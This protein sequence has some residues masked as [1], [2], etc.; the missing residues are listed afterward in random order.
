MQHGLAAAIRDTGR[1]QQES[2]RRVT[3]GIAGQADVMGKIQRD[4]NDIVHLQAVLHQNLSALASASNFEEA[5]HSLTAA[6]HML[7][8]R[9]SGTSSHVHQGK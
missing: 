4:A 7:T 1:D 8:A 5:V 2:L 9:A 3:D 6:V